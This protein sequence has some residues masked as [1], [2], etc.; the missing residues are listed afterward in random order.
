MRAR[1]SVHEV[2]LVLPAVEVQISPSSSASFAGPIARRRRR[3]TSAT[4]RTGRKPF[5]PPG[6]L[7]K[8]RF[9]SP[10]AL[11]F[12][13]RSSR[14]W[15]GAPSSA[16][17]RRGAHRPAKLATAASRTF[18]ESVRDLVDPL[19]ARERHADRRSA[20][21]RVRSA[22]APQGRIG[23]RRG[24]DGEPPN[25]SDKAAH[26]G[27]GRSRRPRRAPARARRRP[28]RRRATTR[29]AGGGAGA[30]RRET[31]R[32]R[33]RLRFHS[34]RVRNAPPEPLE[35]PR[36]RLRE[37][38]ARRFFS[39]GAPPDAIS[40][41]RRR[42]LARARRR[43]PPGRGRRGSA[44]SRGAAF[45]A[46]ASK[47]RRRAGSRGPRRK[48]APDARAGRRRASPGFRPGSGSRERRRRTSMIRRARRRARRTRGSSTKAPR[49]RSGRAGSRRSTRAQGRVQRRTRLRL[50]TL[51]RAGDM[52]I[53]WEG[54]AT[55]EGCGEE[56]VVSRRVEG[57]DGDLPRVERRG[58]VGGR[59]RDRRGRLGPGRTRG[60]DAHHHV[61]SSV[62]SAI[63]ASRDEIRASQAARATRS[64]VVGSMRARAPR[65][66]ASMIDDQSGGT[67]HRHDS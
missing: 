38:S 29:R 7:T 25:A 17:A 33:C 26:A 1:Q 67:R 62:S 21:A 24:N 50:P 63:L 22:P 39:G 66:G 57:G 4:R 43:P 12:R 65:V 20:V 61:P 59:S 35:P 3:A 31:R 11:G 55:R 23:V 44:P 37:R 46:F 49:G 58:E 45:A 47:S 41:R 36:V 53:A 10:R 51:L 16:I 60:V 56:V 5:P 32:R 48:C 19:P 14:R 30:G 13:R 15:H 6:H 28:C 8:R 2:T 34:P 18:A 40:R 27:G 52:A 9:S 42:R 64:D 54:H